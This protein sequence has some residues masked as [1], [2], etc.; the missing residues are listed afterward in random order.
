[1][2]ELALPRLSFRAMGCQ[3]SVLLS[4]PLGAS[5]EA[6][7]AQV[8]IWFAQWERM[9]S[10]FRADSELSRVNARAGEAVTVSAEFFAVVQRAWAMAERTDG[11]VTP[12]LGRTLMALGYDRDFSQLSTKSAPQF[13]RSAPAVA[14]ER[15]TGAD[16]PALICDPERLILTLPKGTHLDLG[17]FVKG[18]CADEVVHRLGAFAPVLM[19][20]G[21]D[22]AVCARMSDD[23]AW[24]VAIA[25][26]LGDHEDLA[27]LALQQGGLATSGRDYRRWVHEGQEQHHIIDPRTGQSAQT[28]VLSVSVLA[29]S[30]FVAESL[31]KYLLIVGRE[32]AQLWWQNRHDVGVCLVLDSGEVVMSPYFERHI[33]H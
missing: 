30:A 25:R 5:S 15:A 32:Q 27:V 22:I 9:F 7:L 19:D 4:A 16:D 28:D 2:N 24:P 6:L 1:M 12:L 18:W 33:W 14:I 11:L 10:R 3:M 8:P 26:P 23:Y 13:D 29:E 21:G 31:A 20:A 17:G